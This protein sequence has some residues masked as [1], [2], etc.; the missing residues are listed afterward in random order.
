MPRKSDIQRLLRQRQGGLT[1]VELM[2]AMVLG[3]L[4]MIGAVQLFSGMRTAYQLNEGL[5]RVQESGRFAIDLLSQDLRMAGYMGCTSNPNFLDIGIAPYLA[6]DDVDQFYLNFTRGVEGYEAVD[7]GPDAT[8]TITTLAPGAGAL[9]DWNPSLPNVFSGESVRPIAGSDVLVIRYMDQ[10]A[11]RFVPPYTKGNQY[12]VTNSEQYLQDDLLFAADCQ[13]GGY[14]F[15]RNNSNKA[16]GNIQ[17]GQGTDPQYRTFGADAELGRARMVIY[18]IGVNVSSDNPDPRPTLY[19]RSLTESGQNVQ[20]DALVGGVETMQVMYGI[21]GGGNRAIDD[22]Q[23]AGQVHAGNRWNSVSSIRVGL[24]V[25]S[26]QQVVPP[27]E[28]TPKQFS[29]LGTDVT[30]DIDDDRRHRQMFTTTIQV[31]NR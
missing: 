8:L 12:H 19:R 16:G 11:V 21:D 29:I 2:I 23:T 5:S 7:T 22:Y 17:P 9:S 18:F 15:R 14:L 24:L 30:V 27:G 3:S 10:D 28:Q 4:L 25:R 1:L 6:D 20:T 26:E 13:G 31:R